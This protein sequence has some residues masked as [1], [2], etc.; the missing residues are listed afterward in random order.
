LRFSLNIS[1]DPVV[2]DPGAEEPWSVWRLLMLGN[3]RGRA[4]LALRKRS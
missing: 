4:A 1:I 3:S 2:G